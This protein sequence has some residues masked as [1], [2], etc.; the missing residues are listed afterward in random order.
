MEGPAR[1]AFEPYLHLRVLV[2]GVVVDH[3]LDQLA[4]WDAALDGIEEADELRAGSG[5]LN[6]CVKWS[7]CMTAAKMAAKQAQR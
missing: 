3:G 2:G 1:V 4:G 5:N 6:R 7:S